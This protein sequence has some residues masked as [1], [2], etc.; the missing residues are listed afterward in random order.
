MPAFPPD[1][2]RQVEK[3]LLNP[4][5]R[6]L[7]LAGC[8][9][10]PFVLIETTGRRTGQPRLTPVQAAIEHQTAWLVAEHG[11]RS[12]FVQ[13]IA[14]NPKVRIR[15]G[16]QW[17]TGRAVIVADEDAWARREKI[18]HANGWLGQLDGLIFRKMAST[19][20]AIRV[21]LDH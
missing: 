16:R 5:M 11:W 20:L 8:A 10:R 21:H 13:N 15:R 7:I 19:P 3:R 18:D 1:L 9:P 4:G 14:A 6:A 2:Q 12:A 17:L